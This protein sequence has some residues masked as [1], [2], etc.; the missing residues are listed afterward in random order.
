[1]GEFT[2]PPAEARLVEGDVQLA[3]GQ[4]EDAAARLE[5]HPIG[6]LEGSGERHVVQVG[7][8]AQSA[9][10]RSRWAA[11]DPQRGMGFLH[12]LGMTERGGIW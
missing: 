1:V 7:G 8:D 6:G 4:R 2:A 10:D 12:G 3:E 9:I 11:R 5:V